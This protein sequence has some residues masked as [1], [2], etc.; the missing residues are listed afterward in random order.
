MQ[1]AGQSEEAAQWFDEHEIFKKEN[2]TPTKIDT[3]RLRLNR[4]RYL[5]ALDI[6]GS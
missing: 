4:E 5:D 2:K 1:Q 3:N 6:S